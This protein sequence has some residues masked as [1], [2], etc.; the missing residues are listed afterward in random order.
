MK[1]IVNEK[2]TYKELESKLKDKSKGCFEITLVACLIISVLLILSTIVLVSKTKE[3][4][5]FKNMYE[6]QVK[7]S[8][9]N[10]TKGINKSF[11]ESELTIERA[12]LKERDRQLRDQEFQFEVRKIKWESQIQVEEAKLQIERERLNLEREQLKIK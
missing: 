4:S 10:Y 3:A 7:K 11:I 1:N 12:K 2:P 9:L 6:L 8:D 5:H